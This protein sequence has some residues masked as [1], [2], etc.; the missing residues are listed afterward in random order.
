MVPSLA[1]CTEYIHSVN[2][3]AGCLSGDPATDVEI[4]DVAFTPDGKLLFTAGWDSRVKVWTWNGSVLAPEGHDLPTGGGLTSLAVSADNK[5][6]AAGAVGGQ[7]TIWN[8]IPTWQV[9]ANL[10]G[11]ANDVNGVAFGPDRT[12][13]AVDDMQNF[14]VYTSANV[15][16]K[17]TMML[18]TFPF[19]IG[20]SPTLSDGSYWLGIGY[21]DGD[22]SLINVN[23]GTLGAEIPFSVSLG[24][25]G[26]Y[27]MKFSFDGRLV[28]SGADDGSFGIWQLP[29]PGSGAP[30]TA[31]SPAINLS[32]DF[33]WS[34]AFH[35]SN[36]YIAVADGSQPSNRRLAIWNVATGALQASVP[37]TS[38][39]FQARSVAFSPNGRALVVGE[40]NCGKVLVCVDP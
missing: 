33:F 40:R 14:F 10:T 21:E 15:A 3:T 19:V 31:L 38:L 29:A 32:T 5:L 28:A 37:L 34:A 9:A 23:G 18:R 26:I 16:P 39:G 7:L 13:Y 27:A 35:S 1:H 30:P 20:A 22:A 17:S 12:L 6:I 25:A 8:I 36:A 11:I 24:I 4:T 2:Q